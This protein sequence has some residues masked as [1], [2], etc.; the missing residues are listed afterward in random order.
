MSHSLV[1]SLTQQACQGD[2]LLPLVRS[3]PSAM[4]SADKLC[5]NLQTALQRYNAIMVQIWYRSSQAICHH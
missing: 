1:T 5:D 2:D 3:N 4:Q